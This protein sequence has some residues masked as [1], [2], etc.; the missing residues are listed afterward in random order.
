MKIRMQH[1]HSQQPFCL[2]KLLYTTTW[3]SIGSDTPSSFRTVRIF[4]RVSRP[5]GHLSPT[6]AL[7]R[8]LSPRPTT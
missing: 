4:E 5:P 7:S 8:A 3:F 6:F 2:V 1:G